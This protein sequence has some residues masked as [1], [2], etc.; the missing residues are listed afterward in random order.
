MEASECTPESVE[1]FQSAVDDQLLREQSSAALRND[2]SALS[3]AAVTCSGA[4]APDGLE[5]TPWIPQALSCL[6]LGADVSMSLM[7]GISDPSQI[8]GECAA[9]AEDLSVRPSASTCVNA[10]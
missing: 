5:N 7:N 1:D 10:N 8:A 9:D 2:R 6:S 4:D 3:A